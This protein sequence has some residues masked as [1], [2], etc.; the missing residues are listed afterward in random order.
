[1]QHP[2]LGRIEGEFRRQHEQRNF[3][4]VRR[5][6]GFKVSQPGVVAVA[7]PD[8][9]AVLDQFDAVEDAAAD[10]GSALERIAPGPCDH[11]GLLTGLEP[12]GQAVESVV[13]EQ[14]APDGR[15]RD[16]GDIEVN[17]GVVRIA[18]L[19]ARGGGGI[20]GFLESLV[21]VVDRQ[22]QPTHGTVADQR[23]PVANLTLAGI[24][25]LFRLRHSAGGDVALVAEPAGLDQ[26]GGGA[27][28][29]VAHDQHGH[30]RAADDVDLRRG[31]GAACDAVH[32]GA[33]Q[34]VD[35][36]YDAF[37]RNAEQND[38]L[39]VLDHLE[40]G[41]HAL[42]RNAHQ[43]L[44]RFAGIA[45]RIGKVGVQIDEADDLIAPKRGHDRGIALRGAEAIGSR[46]EIGRRNFRQ[47]RD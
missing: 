31:R 15:H 45:G 42:R 18:L 16:I 39:L 44:D 38:G 46:K 17:E 13:A 29:A 11:E 12:A 22:D 21:D 25:R 23:L 1:M 41:H 33:D 10:I 2:G 47:V 7:E 5:A 37:F 8:A 19:R 36:I 28:D 26:L 24:D 30:R 6:F 9:V 20:A 35:G 4:K 27:D 3:G 34:F 32:V 40:A 43:N 14:A